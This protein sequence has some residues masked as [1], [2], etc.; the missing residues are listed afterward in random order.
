MREGE[1]KV[2]KERKAGTGD[3]MKIGWN[4][5]F[6]SVELQQWCTLDA[7][8]T[9][10]KDHQNRTLQSKRKKKET[11]GTHSRKEIASAEDLVVGVVV[12]VVVVV[13][14]ALH[15]RGCAYLLD[16]EGLFSGVLPD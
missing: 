8:R 6:L 16:S 11:T 15:L 7:A 4:I 2:I 12:V 10:K 3:L 13:E 9:N 5:L 14:A 1:M